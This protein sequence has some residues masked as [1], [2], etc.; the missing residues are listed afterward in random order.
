MSDN[1]NN[2]AVSGWPAG[3]HL[4]NFIREAFKNENGKSTVRLTE[5]VDPPPSYGQ[6]KISGY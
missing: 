6:L 3:P 2:A 5:K 4:S 1:G